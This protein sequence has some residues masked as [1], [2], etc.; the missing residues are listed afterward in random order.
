MT[1]SIH[2]T[3]RYLKLRRGG[4]SVLQPFR[5]G[6]RFA[7]L[8][9]FGWAFFAVELNLLTVLPWPSHSA[10]VVGLY[11]A[12]A[13]LALS[14]EF[15]LAFSL[16]HFVA[17]SAQSPTTASTSKNHT[18]NPPT[19]TPDLFKR[20]W[21]SAP[22]HPLLLLA[23]FAAL[24]SVLLYLLLLARWQF[25]LLADSIVP[26][27][28]VSNASLAMWCLSIWIL[29]TP[30]AHIGGAIS[31]EQDGYRLYQPFVGGIAHVSLQAFGWMLYSFSGFF[32]LVMRAPTAASFEVTVRWFGPAFLGAL[33]I[34]YVSVRV[35]EPPAMMIVMAIDPTTTSPAS[36]N[37]TRPATTPTTRPKRGLSTATG[38][39]SV[40][41]LIP[42]ALNN[43]SR[44]S[45]GAAVGGSGVNERVAVQQLPSPMSPRN[46]SSNN[47][48]NSNPA[49]TVQAV[50]SPD[51]RWRG[52]SRLGTSLAVLGL[53]VGSAADVWRSSVEPSLQVPMQQLSVLLHVASAVVVHVGA[54]RAMR[55]YRLF[56]PF[57]GPP[58]F[59]VH[60][61]LSWTVFGVCL[62]TQCIVV[63]AAATIV[64][65]PSVV[66]GSGSVLGVPAVQTG[67]LTMTSL[68]HLFAHFLLKGSLALLPSVSSPSGN[69]S[70][71]PS[72][73]RMLHKYDSPVKRQRGSRTKVDVV[74]EH[75]DAAAT[76]VDKTK[77]IN[78]PIDV[79]ATAV[80]AVAAAAVATEEAHGGGKRCQYPDGCGKSAQGSTM[81]CTAHGGGKRFKYFD[82]CD[83]SARVVDEEMDLSEAGN[84][85]GN[86]GVVVIEWWRSHVVG[87]VAGVVSA[88]CAHLSLGLFLLSEW[89]RFAKISWVASDADHI[90]P[91]FPE[92]DT[93]RTLS[94]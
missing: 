73:L 32:A 25:P 54:S 37:S 3:Y 77:G 94:E 8:Q 4:F 5:G 75:V 6:D 41:E 55:G 36:H 47:N 14:A 20:S 61:A 26:H 43:Q 64:P 59:V 21:H 33:T 42:L 63:G 15:A 71:N 22:D 84:L 74:V 89:L 16:A 30:I 34:I 91:D 17:L 79:T 56:H 29:V 46:N 11:V 65:G 88:V 9:G 10:H 51:A 18:H 50:Y 70:Y 72:A 85:D 93:V 82:G 44:H 83:E 78:A 90:K 13:L 23:K 66:V 12:L 48:N 1:S 52:Q 49:M 87:V 7:L 92:S 58:A 39:S 2:Q 57:A 24:V 27:S 86:G 19:T 80:A 68:G 45:Q 62:M 81:F 76:I 67:W 53:L 28:L 31:R 40:D 35:F 60:Q 38:E 69:Y